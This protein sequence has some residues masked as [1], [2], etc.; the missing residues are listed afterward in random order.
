MSCGERSISTG[1]LPVMKTAEEGLKERWVSSSTGKV[2]PDGGEQNY[3][4]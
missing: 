1:T 2:G 3:P 4:S